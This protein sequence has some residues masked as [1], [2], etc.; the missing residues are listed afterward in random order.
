MI[1]LESVG[2][3]TVLINLEGFPS[4]VPGDL[5][6]VVGGNVIGGEILVVVGLEGQ[7]DSEIV[8]DVG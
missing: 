4:E 7:V 6:D 8:V 5:E 1:G 3:V 2:I